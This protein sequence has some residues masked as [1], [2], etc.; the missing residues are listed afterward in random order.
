MSG[1]CAPATLPSPTLLARL[2]AVGTPTLSSQ[3]IKNGLRR[4]FLAG[5]RQLVGDRAIC[6]LAFTL[7]FV[8]ERDDKAVPAS[9]GW[10]NA[11]PA[12]IDAAPAGSI[13]V[14]DARG[15]QGAGTVGDI[16]ADRLRIQG[17]QGIISDGVVRDLPG[18]RQVGLPVWAS[19]TASPPSIGGLSFAGW[20]EP[21][22]C[23]DAAI[24]P[25]DLIVADEDGVLVV[26][27]HLAEDI[28]TGGEKQNRIEAWVQRRVAAGAQL[29]GLYPADAATLAEFEAE[30]ASLHRLQPDAHPSNPHEGS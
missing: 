15:H 1:S 13:V 21:I 12:A 7:R 2:A 10:P 11:L 24:W 30:E 22:G 4:S 28:V 20:G 25:G 3:L 19:G 18:L 17:V 26:P 5:P 14:I 6:G 27:L 8:P 29:V 16:F 23:G 9:Y